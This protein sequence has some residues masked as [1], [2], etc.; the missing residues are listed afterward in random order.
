MTAAGYSPS[1]RLFEAAACSVPII[2]DRWIGLDTF[3]TPGDEI[4][5]ADNTEQVVSF[6]T[7]VSEPKRQKIALSARKRVL[8]SHTAEQ[9]AKTLEECYTE[10]ARSRGRIDAATCSEM[11]AVA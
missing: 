11:G 2:S 3:L 1:V 5:V 7:T 8:Q 6:L 4:L 9:R 10:A